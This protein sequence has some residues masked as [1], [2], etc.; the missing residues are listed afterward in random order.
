MSR[1]IRAIVVLLAILPVFPPAASARSLAAIE[2]SGTLRL[3]VAGAS[4]DFY[5]HNGLA[6][7]R[8]LGVKAQVERLANWDTQFE[9]GDGLIDTAATYVARRLADGSC[10]VFPNDLHVVA[11][12]QSKMDLLPYYSTR[13]VVVARRDLRPQL[14]DIGDLKGLRA[15]VQKGTAYDTWLQDENAGRLAAQPVTIAYFPT[16]QAMRAVAEGSADFTVVGSE[17]AF[18][19][20]R[21]DLDRLDIVFP[22]GEAVAVGWGMAPQASDLR[23]RIAAFFDANRHVGSDLDR[24]WHKHY[25]VSLM[26]YQLYFDSFKA[27]GFPIDTLLRWGLPVAACVLAIVSAI[28]LRNARLRC[29]VRERRQTEERISALL[30]QQT[31]FFAFVAHELR[32]PLGVIV[33]GLANLRV[34]L[35]GSDDTV[36]RRIDRIS[37][38]TQ[39]LSAL[40]DRHL[41]LQRLMR[42]DF[43]LNLEEC[44]PG[45][46]A[47]LAIDLVADAHAQR[48][49]G[50]AMADDVP[51]QISIDT[52]LVTLAIVNLLDNAIKYSPASSSSSPDSPVSLR[53]RRDPARPTH[54]VYEV[55]DHGPGIAPA[56]RERLFDIYVRR[57]RGENG[58]FGIGL[59]LVSSIAR[60]HGGYIDCVS[61]LGAGSTFSLSL[62]IALPN[63]GGGT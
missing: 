52:E 45:F 59:A 42:A 2:A 31:R 30:E 55:S 50:Y 18:R 9:N 17:G 56:D 8:F 32:N 10:D 35:A 61:V 37:G 57:S 36:K 14:R 4:A 21:S 11:W 53:I 51:A 29:E 41:R 19:W 38:A 13:K 24:A 49:I 22:V 26:E 6:L 25:G 12:R 33:S 5:A 7:A 40:I 62:P 34:G 20:M 23:A 46:P 48:E 47:V 3:C 28:L 16:D 15:A 58:G 54:V 44:S 27:A 1:V 39:R 60:H 63:P 43:A